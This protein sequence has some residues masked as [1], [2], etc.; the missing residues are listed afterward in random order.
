MIGTISLDKETAQFIREGY[1]DGHLVERVMF[2]NLPIPCHIT[3]VSTYHPNIT[4]KAATGYAKRRATDS[5]LSKSSSKPL[6]PSL[7]RSL[8]P[9]VS[10]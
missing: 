3:V 7:E 4:A 5:G 10:H 9:I 1:L 6:V 2:V 8:N